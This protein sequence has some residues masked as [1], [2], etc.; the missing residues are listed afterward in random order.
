MNRNRS[1][2]DRYLDAIGDHFASYYYRIEAWLSM[3]VLG[4]NRFAAVS[5]GVSALITNF[6]RIHLTHVLNCI[7]RHLNHAYLT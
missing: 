7:A 5:N 2:V 6:S 1:D 4:S 3:D